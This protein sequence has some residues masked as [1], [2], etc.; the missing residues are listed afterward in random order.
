MTEPT[1]KFATADT[2]NEH[3][4]PARGGIS[5]EVRELRLARKALRIPIHDYLG[6]EL[7]AL[8]PET[9]AVMH[10]SE[11][12]RSLGIAVHGGAL[13]TLADLVGNLSA[14]L[15]AA[16]DWRYSRLRTIDLNMKFVRQPGGDLVR[17]VACRVADGSRVIRTQV[18]IEDGSEA[19]V[20]VADLTS[21]IIPSAPPASS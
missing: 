8:R 7:V 9:V 5:A 1:T 11:R 16:F 2:P 6:I 18:R 14:S 4:A 17:A 21:I 10:V 12:T 19:L 20:G 3:L 13:A 15:S